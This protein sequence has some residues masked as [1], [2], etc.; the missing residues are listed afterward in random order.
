MFLQISSANALSR[1]HAGFRG[2]K[3]L[4]VEGMVGDQERDPPLIEAGLLTSDAL[5]ACEKLEERFVLS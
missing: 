3:T 5:L 2:W 1:G 4:R